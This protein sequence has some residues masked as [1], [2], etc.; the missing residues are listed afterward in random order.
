MLARAIRNENA[1]EPNMLRNRQ[2]DERYR[3][4]PAVGTVPFPKLKCE[5]EGASR[6]PLTLLPRVS[7]SPFLV[8]PPSGGYGFP[9]GSNWMEVGATKILSKVYGPQRKRQ[10]RQFTDFAELEVSVKYCSYASKEERYPYKNQ[11]EA[12]I[13][14]QR[15]QE[16]LKKVILLDRYPNSM[17]EVV[18]L[19]VE[20]DG[21]VFS[22]CMNSAMMSLVNGGIEVKDMNIHCEFGYLDDHTILLD[23]CP[24]EQL[25]CIRVLS[26][27]ICY[28]QQCITYYTCTGKD[29]SIQ[30]VLPIALDMVQQLSPLIFP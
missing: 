4:L 10:Q 16:V 5:A 6:S 25:Q 2:R 14:A 11:E 23:P 18:I 26:I 27:G 15:V 12:N 29:I 28:H 19:V 9:T 30:Q 8:P 21:N 22:S 20:Q 1:I 24:S 17:I 3:N 13:L 7:Q